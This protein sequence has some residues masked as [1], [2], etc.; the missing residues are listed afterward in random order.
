MSPNATA[1][2]PTAPIA[3]EED[4]EEEIEETNE[5]PSD[6]VKAETKSVEESQEEIINENSV[7][8][9]TKSSRVR[10][11]LKKC[12]DRWLAVGVHN[13]I[14]ELN[15]TGH[16]LKSTMSTTNE[17]NVSQQQ[18]DLRPITTRVT[19]SSRGSSGVVDNKCSLTNCAL[20]NLAEIEDDDDDVVDDSYEDIDFGLG[21]T[22]KTTT[23]TTTSK[24]LRKTDKTSTSTTCKSNFCNSTSNAQIETRHE[25]L[26]L[27]S[28][29]QHHRQGDVVEDAEKHVEQLMDSHQ[30]VSVLLSSCFKNNILNFIAL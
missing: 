11:Y 8:R 17:L 28:L 23:T 3:R 21:S 29:A 27:K 30:M 18:E 22:T 16:D 10:N 2:N 9:S 20:G 5:T 14:Q 4:A 6:G 7:R 1:P 15:N 24:A 19:V 26:Q 12:K 13:Q 25:K